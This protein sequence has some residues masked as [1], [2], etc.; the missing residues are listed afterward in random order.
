MLC[1]ENCKKEA[2]VVTTCGAAHTP[3]LLGLYSCLSLNTLFSKDTLGV[4]W[5]NKKGHL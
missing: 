3:Q 1:V 4:Q 5:E 2:A